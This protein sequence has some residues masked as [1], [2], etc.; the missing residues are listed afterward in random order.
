M[1]D[2]QGKKSA[3]VDDEDMDPTVYVIL[4]H[5]LLAFFYGLFHKIIDYD[6]NS[7]FCFLRFSSCSNTSKIG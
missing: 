4:V 7:C 2:S 3:A 1:V 5:Y 6:I